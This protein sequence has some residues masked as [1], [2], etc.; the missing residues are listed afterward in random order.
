MCCLQEFESKHPQPAGPDKLMKEELDAQIELLAS[1]EKKY[2]DPGPA[3]DC[4]V[5]HD[6]EMWR[7]VSIKK[8]LELQRL[9][10]CIFLERVWIHLRLGT[11]PAVR[12][13]D[14]SARQE[15]L[16]C[17]PSQISY[18]TVL[19]SMTRA[20]PSRL[21]QCVVSHSLS[22]SPKIFTFICYRTL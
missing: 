13:W 21:S 6:G 5:F 1:F 7:Y 4:V 16:Q 3:Y 14:L 20:I 10:V 12:Y 22:S 17:S 9:S 18:T 11:W 2:N 15:T 19:T 8:P